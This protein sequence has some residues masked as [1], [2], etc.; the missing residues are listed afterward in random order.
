MMASSFY[1]PGRLLEK[2]ERISEM[3]VTVVVAPEGYG[4][5][6]IVAQKTA[7]SDLKTYWIDSEELIAKR[8]YDRICEEFERI[9]PAFAAELA[10]EG[11]PRSDNALTIMNLIHKHEEIIDECIV[12]FDKFQLLQTLLPDRL[13]SALLHHQ[14]RKLHLVFLT[15]YMWEGLLFD[16]GAALLI[17]TEDFI[18]DSSEIMRYFG[19]EKTE[20]SPEE[21]AHIFELTNGWNLAVYSLLQKRIYASAEITENETQSCLNKLILNRYSSDLNHVMLCLNPFD[22]FTDE[23]ISFVL[24]D[25]L[26]LSSILNKLRS[27]P[28]VS[29]NLITH[30]YH[31]HPTVSRCFRMLLDEMSLAQ[32]RWIFRRAGDYYGSQ[33]NTIKQLWCYGESEDDELILQL[34][35]VT[36]SHYLEGDENYADLA[37]SI[38]KRCSPE[39][40]FQHPVSLLCFARQLFFVGRSIAAEQICEKLKLHAEQSGDNSLLGETAL[41]CA[42]GE[43]PRISRMREEYETAAR[44]LAGQSAIFQASS[45]F[46]CGYPSMAGLF[47]LQPGYAD[48]TAEEFE[49]AIRIFTEISGGQGAGADLL[50]RGELALM[51]CQFDEALIFAYKAETAAGAFSQHG[52]LAGVG[53]LKGY[54]S[55]ARKDQRMLNDALNSLNRILKA[56]EDQGLTGCINEKVKISISLLLHLSG[57]PDS[58]PVSNMPARMTF[59]NDG[60]HLIAFLHNLLDEKQYA[61]LIGTVESLSEPLKQAAVLQRIDSLLLVALSYAGLGKNETAVRLVEEALKMAEED[62]ILFPFSVRAELLSGFLPGS[63][64]GRISQGTDREMWEGMSQQKLVKNLTDREREVAALAAGGLRNREIAEKLYLSDGTVRNHLSVIYQKLDIDRRA[65]LSDYE[66]LLLNHDKIHDIDHEL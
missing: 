64:L 42:L 16:P 22:R 53:L 1:F 28:L 40:L 46:L 47:H 24:D 2:L 21:A 57:R 27:T 6:T 25:H 48:S 20:I 19:S 18:I 23:T 43:F 7:E 3:P 4:K 49:Q 35:H 15:S 39:I 14:G 29:Y 41:V 37:E 63:L 51:R 62:Q 36:I 32:K 34:D 30:E 65:K 31:P 55:I 45:S 10:E 52:I 26:V 17:D 58:N 56:T 50:F 54:I 5:T 33:G 66:H 44:L 61:R 12:V 59:P 11:L 8:Q 9:S 60:L 38:L 13:L